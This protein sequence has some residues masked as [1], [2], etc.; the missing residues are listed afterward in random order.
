MISFGKGYELQYYGPL[1]HFP[2]FDTE[3][4]PHLII[5]SLLIT[6]VTGCQLGRRCIE[7]W[8]LA[9]QGLFWIR[10][11]AANGSAHANPLTNL[12][13]RVEKFRSGVGYS[14]FPILGRTFLACGRIYDS[15][16]VID[17]GHMT[18]VGLFSTCTLECKQILPNAYTFQ[19]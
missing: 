17:G 14:L 4:S 10:L 18:Y 15:D 3:I 2:T 12:Y 19:V 6:G 11:A 13:A 8:L 16:I 1:T 7:A 5:P 9:R